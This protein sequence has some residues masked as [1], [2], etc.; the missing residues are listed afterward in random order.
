[1][2]AHRFALPR[3]ALPSPPP[4]A[5][6]GTTRPCRPARLARHRGGRPDL[7]LL[8][9]LNVLLLLLTAL[10]SPA[11]A[12]DITLRVG[13]QNYYNIRAS[14]ELSKALEGAPYKVQWGQF[15]SAAPLAEAMGS[16]ALDIGFLGDSGFL[17]L[18]SRNPDA[19]LIGVT[20]QNPRTVALLVPK[21]SPAQR[22]EDLKGK[23]VAYW[24]GAWSQQLTLAALEKAGLGSDYVDWVKLM[25]LDAATALPGGS[26]D[27]FPVWEPYISQQIVRSGARA[28][29]TAEGVIPALSAIAAHGPSIDGKAEAIADFLAR[30]KVARAWVEANV[31]TYAEAWA[32]RANLDPDVARHWLRQAK[33]TAGPVD[34]GSARDLQATADFLH[35]VKVLAE[36]LDTRR[37]IEPRFE[38][39]LAR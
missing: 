39:T 26:I 8:A 17:F 29:F 5:A 6:P 4:S 9:V 36:P 32:K 25:P 21:D 35:Q 28:L 20:R 24:P 2:T 27:A 3:F 11:R 12:Q 31:D 33:L 22:L 15:Q 18:A 14:F 16:G 7:T 23:R 38:K 10:A 1:M 30:L 13:D 34:V 37:V 19:K